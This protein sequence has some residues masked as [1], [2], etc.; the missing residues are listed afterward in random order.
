MRKKVKLPATKRPQH[1]QKSQGRHMDAH[2]HSQDQQSG[3]FMS[4]CFHHAKYGEQACYCKEGCL[5]AEK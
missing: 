3:L 4:M 1:Q 5:W 2:S